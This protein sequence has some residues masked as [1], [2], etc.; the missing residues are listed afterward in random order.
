MLTGP[1]LSPKSGK[2]PGQLIVFLHGYGADGANLID[3]GEYWSDLLPDAEFIAP[4]AIEPCEMGIGYQWFG[5]K[6]FSPFNIRAGLDRVTPLVVKQ[7]KVWLHE[8]QLAPADL[9]LVGFSQGTM[10]ALDIMF[11]LPGI[12][13][14]VGYSGAF[15]PPVA[16]QVKAPVPKVCLIHGDMDMVVPYMAFLEAQKNLQEYGI[17][18]VTHTSHG[19][20]HSI[21]IDGLRVGGQFLV[22]GL[23]TTDSVI[24]A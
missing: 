23:V 2:K 18:P 11:H 21:D 20:G 17:I 5:L 4:N 16:K 12:K 24:L 22:E 8:R 13:A 19:L 7:L 10:L 3:I 9:C 14:I 15:Y 6:D 1:S